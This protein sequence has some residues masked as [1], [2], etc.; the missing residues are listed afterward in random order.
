MAEEPDERV[1]QYAELIR[2]LFEE[3]MKTGEMLPGEIS[4]IIAAASVPTD[5]ETETQQGW[6]KPDIREPVSERY[7]HSGIV[8]ITADLPGT[9]REDIRY[10]IYGRVLYLA[11]RADKVIYRAAYP[12]DEAAPDSLT[13]TYK[14]GVIEFTYKK[15]GI[16]NEKE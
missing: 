12:I 4:I 9:A 13:Q 15:E 2:R 10:A 11:A 5:N 14:N 6:Q 7:E 3:A 8:T 16:R 1:N